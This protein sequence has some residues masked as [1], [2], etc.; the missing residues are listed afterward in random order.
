[1]TDKNNTDELKRL[2]DIVEDIHNRLFVDNGKPS[3]QTTLRRHDDI[4][5]VMKWILVPVVVA[6]ITMAIKSYVI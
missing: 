3:F 4:L 1:M 5:V 6:I 2:G